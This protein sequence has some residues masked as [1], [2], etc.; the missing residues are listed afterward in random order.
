MKKFIVLLS[1]LFIAGC[2]SVPKMKG[3]NDLSFHLTSTAI[4]YLPYPKINQSI[5]EQQLLTT[6]VNGHELS[7]MSILNRDNKGLRLTA[8]SA[9]GVRLFAIDYDGYSVKVEKYIPNMPLPDAN[10]IIANIML[11]YYDLP[12]WKDHLPKGWVMKDQS[13]IREVLDANDQI[14]IQIAYEKHHNDYLPIMITNNAL[15]YTIN[16]K[17]LN[18]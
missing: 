11:A 13:L 17:N 15:K 10:D 12:A 8:L 5:E 6:T 14:I 1:V 3:E 7:F 9:V 16:L 18:D 4:G 2:G